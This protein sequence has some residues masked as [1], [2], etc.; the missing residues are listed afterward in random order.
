MSQVWCESGAV[1]VR[2]GVSQVWCESGVS[3]LWF[4]LQICCVQ[5]AGVNKTTWQS[6]MSLCFWV[7][8][9]VWER[10]NLDDSG[11]SELPLTENCE[12][13]YPV[14]AT[15]DFT[16]Q[17]PIPHGRFS[18]PWQHRPPYPQGVC[19]SHMTMAI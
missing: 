8:Q 10:W 11:R 12:E 3:E 13:T 9:A 2:C 7:P 15:V 1:L 14:G 17:T 4:E 18:S 5:Y 16:S 6:Y 19:V